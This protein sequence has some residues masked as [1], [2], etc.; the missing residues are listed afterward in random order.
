[1]AVRVPPRRVKTLTEATELDNPIPVDEENTAAEV[2]IHFSMD[3][4]YAVQMGKSL[5]FDRLKRM[6]WEDAKF[7]RDHRGAKVIYAWAASVKRFS[8]MNEKLNDCIMKMT[9]SY[10]DYAVGYTDKAYAE[11]LIEQSEKE[12]HNAMS[13]QGEQLSMW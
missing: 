1:M 13:C 7:M 3:G 10:L 6:C 2:D 12:Y 5:T 9:A 11:A 4:R 8:G